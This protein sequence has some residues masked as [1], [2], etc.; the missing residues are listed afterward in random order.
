[1]SHAEIVG[2][3]GHVATVADQSGTVSHLAPADTQVPPLHSASRSC[4]STSAS[5]SDL[6]PGDNS[7]VLTIYEE[8]H[9]PVPHGGTRA[10]VI[11]RASRCPGTYRSAVRT[12]VSLLR[13]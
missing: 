9:L 8:T 13:S 1:M 4:A 5:R 12:S 3:D 2:L 10:G 11:L 7:R 6:R